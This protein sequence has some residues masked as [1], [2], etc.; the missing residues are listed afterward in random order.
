VPRVGGRAACTKFVER[1]L[2]LHSRLKP[3]YGVL[4]VPGTG[5]PALTEA[6]PTTTLEE[7][8]ACAAKRPG[9]PGRSS[10]IAL[11]RLEA[12]RDDGGTLVVDRPNA[13]WAGSPP[14][15][16]CLMPRRRLWL[17]LASVRLAYGRDRALM[18]SGSSGPSL[19]AYV[20]SDNC[21]GEFVEAC[22]PPG[23][24]VVARSQMTVRFIKK[25]TKIAKAGDKLP[26]VV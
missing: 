13:P 11:R 3:L 23:G 18:R 6:A 24:M 2:A 21:Y 16:G 7:V 15:N 4:S 22:E 8:T 25:K 10:V 5:L 1:H 26:C 17:Q 12:R 14:G 20:L 19:A 9:F